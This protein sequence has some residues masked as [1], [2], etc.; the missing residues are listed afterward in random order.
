MSGALNC[1]LGGTGPFSAQLNRTDLTG[2]RIGAG[3]AET[4]ESVTC[5]PVNGIPP[6]TYLWSYDS[7]DSEI[8][9]YTGT[10]NTTKFGAYMT[11]PG[12][13]FEATWICTITD[14]GTNT[15][16]SVPVTISL[17]RAY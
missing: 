2:F 11:S 1:L 3:I 15:T 10:S 9:P 7:G 17:Y 4:S 8:F 5:S 16:D 12:D 6:F 14:S 13:Y